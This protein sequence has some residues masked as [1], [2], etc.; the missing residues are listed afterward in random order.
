MHRASAHV[1]AHG[2][3]CAGWRSVQGAVAQARP[4]AMV[5]VAQTLR[6]DFYQGM[7]GPWRACLHLH[8]HIRHLRTSWQRL[9]CTFWASMSRRLAGRMSAA[10]VDV[11]VTM[12]AV[13]SS[14]AQPGRRD[15]DGLSTA[16]VYRYVIV[17]LSSTVATLACMLRNSPQQGA[18]RALAPPFR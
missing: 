3:E 11:L 8:A 15:T 13:F 5:A 1:L 7:R 4:L 14:C 17:G 16:H 10:A 2:I 9:R 12:Q 18:R 6:C